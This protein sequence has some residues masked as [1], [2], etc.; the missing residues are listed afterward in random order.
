MPRKERRVVTEHKV[1]FTR[2]ETLTML[3]SNVCAGDHIEIPKT[4]TM[5]MNGVNGDLVFI[6]TVAETYSDA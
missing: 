6:W 2:E 1:I 4:A 3:T 5:S